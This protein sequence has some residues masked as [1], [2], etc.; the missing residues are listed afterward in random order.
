MKNAHRQERYKQ[1]RA[2][3]CV[4]RIVEECNFLSQ[5]R[6]E[7]MY[8]QV[9]SQSLGDHHKTSLRR[10]T[11]RKPRHPS[12][13]AKDSERNCLSFDFVMF[14]IQGTPHRTTANDTDDRNPNTVMYFSLNWS[15]IHIKWGALSINCTNMSFT[16][17]LPAAPVNLTH[18]SGRLLQNFLQQI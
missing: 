13:D 4:P 9:V 12:T 15:L 16:P 14:G 11:H 10:E 6:L 1:H 3:C 7:R 2:L 17:R 5:K 8:S 18:V